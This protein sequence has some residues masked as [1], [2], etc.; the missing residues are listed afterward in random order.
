MP[1]GEIQKKV[2]ETFGKDHIL[3]HIAQ[4]ESNFTHWNA[5]GR[6]YRGEVN[7]Q[8]IGVMQI[9]TYYHGREARRLGYNL[10][11]LDGNMAYAKYLYDHE[12]T[13]PWNSS[14]YCWRK[15]QSMFSR[16]LNR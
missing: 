2:E 16:L 13:K 12:G 5:N 7:P 6:I 10:K 8:D 3:V 1:S 4:C 9:N 11:S 15:H 14:A